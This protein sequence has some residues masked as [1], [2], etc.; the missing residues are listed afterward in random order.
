[1]LEDESGFVQKGSGGYSVLQS[2]GCR[3]P[4]VQIVHREAL[5]ALEGGCTRSQ[6][7]KSLFLR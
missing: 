3:S 4:V 6:S 5:E 1:M 7:L 2:K